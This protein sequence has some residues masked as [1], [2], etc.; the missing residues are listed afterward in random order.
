MN[1]ILGFMKGFKCFDVYLTEDRWSR[2]RCEKGTGDTRSLSPDKQE[3][4]TVYKRRNPKMG[5]TM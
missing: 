5:T 4:R 3:D 1:R 2:D